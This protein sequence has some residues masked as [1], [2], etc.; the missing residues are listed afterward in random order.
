MPYTPITMPCPARS[1]DNP[2]AA[3]AK[4]GKNVAEIKRPTRP[5]AN[6]K[7]LRFARCGASSDD[8]PYKILRRNSQIGGWFST[9]S[10]GKAIF[11]EKNEKKSGRKM[12]LK[13]ILFHKSLRKTFLF[14]AF[15]V[16]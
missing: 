13:F 14:K 3:S 8:F 1:S 15:T 2:S 10:R 12:S 9:L 16:F 7:R 4:P 11:F 6:C 5:R